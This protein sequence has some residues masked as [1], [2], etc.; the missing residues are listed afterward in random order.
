MIRA[1]IAPQTLHDQGRSGGLMIAGP[2]ATVANSSPGPAHPHAQVARCACT[3]RKRTHNDLPCKKRDMRKGLP[4][5]RRFCG[6]RASL[7]MEAEAHRS[8]Q[9]VAMTHV[10]EMLRTYPADLG[11]VN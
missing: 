7:G 1:V 4:E 11:D 6:C 8:G 5:L 3:W 2:A 9:V 10:E